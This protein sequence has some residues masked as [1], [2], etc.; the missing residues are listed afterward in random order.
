VSAGL[1]PLLLD[2]SGRP[3]RAARRG[4]VAA[5]ALAFGVAFAVSVGGSNSHP[6]RAT[7]ASAPRSAV[8]AP[9]AVARLQRVAPLPGP[10]FAPPP[11]PAPVAQ[12]T[13]VRATPP[14]VT[15]SE[16]ATTPAPVPA[17]T[18]TTTTTSAPAPVAPAPP[19]PKTFDSS[20]SQTFDSSG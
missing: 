10:R 20:G 12:V 18:T 16:A 19:P 1:T 4:L 5:L 8:A 9:P 3:R 17:V 6:V 14:P 13:P 15:T 7:P 11:P 2:A